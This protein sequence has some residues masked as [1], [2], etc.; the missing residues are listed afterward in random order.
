MPVL[1]FRVE[2]LEELTGLPIGVIEDL[3]FRLKCETEE[4]PDGEILEVEINPDRP[5]MYIGEGLARAVLG[6]AGKRKGW[7]DLSFEES[8]LKLV[9][10]SPPS[11]P[12][13]VAAIVYNVNVDEAYLEELIQFQEKLHDTIG[14]RRR[15]VAIGFHDLEKLPSTTLYYREEPVDKASF[16]PLHGTRPMTAARILEETDQGVAYGKIS[17]SNGKHPFLYSGDEIIAMPPV[18]NSNLTRIEPGTRHLFIDVTGTDRKTVEKTLDIIV[19]NLAEREGA[20]PAR[21]TVV[22]GHVSRAT[23]SYTPTITRL[24][25]DYVNRVLGTNL[26]VDEIASLLSRTGHNSDL[27]EGDVLDVASPPYRVDILGPIDL[28]EDVAIALGYEELGYNRPVVI[29]PGRLMD[30]TLLARTLRDLAI[31]FGFTEI[32][33][34]TLTSPRLLD[35]LGIRERVEVLNPVQY[36]YS[37]LRPSI[38]PSLLSTLQAN[39]HAR[40]PVK[41]FEIGSIVLPGDPPVD[42]LAMGLAIMDVEVGYED[43]QAVVYSLLRILDLRFTVEPG[44]KEFLLPGRRAR[45]IVEGEP[46][47]FI[48]EVSPEVLERL[49]IEYPVALAELDVEVLAK[50]KSRM[51]GRA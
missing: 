38:A 12:H 39:Q 16:T 47:G 49:A 7:R 2:R 42:R 31:G 8:G 28:V 35:A 26:N 18:I 11:R 15:K 45:I 24:S 21:V 20:R 17:L 10:M 36:E 32:M 29:D 48:G 44:D 50:W 5:D 43:I 30:K 1:K 27:G 6:L 19:G 23:P 40:K 51:Q 14:R 25:A 3:L 33:Q 22:E 41:I 13:I 34:L 9:N 4:S 46:A 37:V